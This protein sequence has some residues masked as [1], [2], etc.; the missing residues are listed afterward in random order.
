MGLRNPRESSM[1]RAAHHWFGADDLSPTVDGSD[2]PIDDWRSPYH[3]ELSTF[4]SLVSYPMYVLGSGRGA[5]F[6][7]EM[8]EQAFPS[9]TRPSWPMRVSRSAV[10]WLI[11][12]RLP[13]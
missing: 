8:D 5:L 11:G 7:P 13:R 9:K 12:L 4:L 2:A 6:V 10:R 3:N 1:L